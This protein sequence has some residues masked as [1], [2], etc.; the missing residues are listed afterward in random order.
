MY[1]I[2]EKYIKAMNEVL[3]DYIVSTIK[4]NCEDRVVAGISYEEV[5]IAFNDNKE[6]FPNMSR[7]LLD[8]NMDEILDMIEDCYD[9]SGFGLHGGELVLFCLEGFYDNI[10]FKAEDLI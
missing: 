10:D 9:Y 4:L 5:I 8:N 6:K 3:P 7:E 1:K 2:P